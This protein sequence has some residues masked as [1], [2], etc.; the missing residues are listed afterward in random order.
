LSGGAICDPAT[1]IRAA[2]DALYAAKARGRNR[3]VSVAPAV[4]AGV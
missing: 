1:L 2:G 3:V 4:V